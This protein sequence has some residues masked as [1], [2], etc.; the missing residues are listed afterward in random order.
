MKS[1][2]QFWN[3]T[4]KLSSVEN[5]KYAATV[6]GIISHAW[7]DFRENFVIV[8][9]LR[10][11]STRTDN[12]PLAISQVL[13]RKCFGYFEGT[14]ASTFLFNLRSAHSSTRPSYV[15]RR[16]KRRDHFSRRRSIDTKAIDLS[17]TKVVGGKKR[18]GGRTN[19]K[20]RKRG[21]TTRP[22]GF[23][24]SFFLSAISPTM[25]RTGRS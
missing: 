10:I 19:R 2:F 20:E 13:S 9:R 22:A 12:V 15:N 24:A 14:R 8:E 5:L 4:R 23:Y 16:L 7:K 6:G 3:R 11:F 18:R 21:K 1:T 17:V 25:R